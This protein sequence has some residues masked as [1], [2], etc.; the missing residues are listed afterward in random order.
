MYRIPKKP[1]SRISSFLKKPDIRPDI[2]SFYLFL[3]NLQSSIHLSIMLFTFFFHSPQLI[4]QYFN[5]NLWIELNIQY[6][7]YIRPAGYLAGYRILKKAG[8][9]TRY[10]AQPGRISGT[11]LVEIHLTEILMS[12]W[13]NR[14]IWDIKHFLINTY[15]VHFSTSYGFRGSP[16]IH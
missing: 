7:R 15:L 10:P 13:P 3:S 2:Q 1:D 4:S 8:Y 16:K 9:P 14:S 5:R 12:Q 11:S 6:I